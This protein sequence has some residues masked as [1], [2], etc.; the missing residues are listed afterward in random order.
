MHTQP[1]LKSHEKVVYGVGPGLIPPSQPSYIPQY[2]P[3][4]VVPVPQV[5]QPTCKWIFLSL[6]KIGHHSRSWVFV[7]Y[8]APSKKQNSCCK[9]N[10]RC[11]GGTGGVLLVLCLLALAIWLGGMITLMFCYFQ[12]NITES[13]S[14]VDYHILRVELEFAHI[15]IKLLTFVLKYLCFGFMKLFYLNQ[16]RMSLVVTCNTCNICIWQY[17]DQKKNN[18]STLFS[19][20]ILHVPAV[21]SHFVNCSTLP[22]PLSQSLADLGCVHTFCVCYGSDRL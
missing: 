2:A 6:T 4:V 3:S 15:S 18:N 9:N 16:L 1:P 17:I 7:L 14:S 13:F 11:Y 10:A 8:P 20:V 21:T 12:Q 5:T 19:A 22:G